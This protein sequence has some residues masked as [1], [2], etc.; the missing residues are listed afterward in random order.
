MKKSIE[1]WNDTS[2]DKFKIK[3]LKGILNKDELGKPFIEYIT[4]IT[5]N[6]Q[7]WRINKK[8]NQFAN[9]HKSL[10]NTFPDMKFP[11]SASIFSKILEVSNNNFHENKI[12]QLE[13]YL[14]DISE[15]PFIN[16]SKQFRKFFDF[17]E[18]YDETS[19]NKD[20]ILIDDQNPEEVIQ[21]SVEKEGSE[22]ST[23]DRE[24]AKKK[25]TF[26]SMI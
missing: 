6:T 7:N 1:K 12:K 8:F 17:D 5:F 9:L 22:K 26:I 11:E 24:S 10:K 20:K 2:S 3:I 19:D 21:D 23:N 25:L 18:Y 15:I 13:K 16:K 14:K 4:D